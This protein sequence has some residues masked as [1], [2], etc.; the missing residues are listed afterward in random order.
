MK[1]SYGE[2]PYANFAD[3]YV[4]QTRCKMTSEPAFYS[5]PYIL[6]GALCFGA[7]F[8]FVSMMVDLVFDGVFRLSPTALGFAAAAFMGYVAVAWIVRRSEAQT[9]ES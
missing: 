6:A 5:P 4:L 7:L 9:G 3:L 1:T 2:G 8:A